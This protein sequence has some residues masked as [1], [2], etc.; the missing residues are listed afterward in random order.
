MAAGAGEVVAGGRDLRVAHAVAEQHDHVLRVTVVD[1]TLEVAHLVRA[2]L[3][4]DERGRARADGRD[5]GTHQRHARREPSSHSVLLDSEEKEG[6][7]SARA[8]S[9]FR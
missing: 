4:S 5:G 8:A 1:L 3:R 2:A 6:R 9:G 7:Y